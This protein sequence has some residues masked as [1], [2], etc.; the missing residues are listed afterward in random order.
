[1]QSEHEE[2]YEDG[3]DLCIDKIKQLEQQVKDGYQQG[4][5]EGAKKAM[6]ELVDYSQEVIRLK[7]ENREL[8]QQVLELKEKAKAWD[9]LEALAN[10]AFNEDEDRYWELNIYDSRVFL[11]SCL[12]GGTTI[13]FEA[14]LHDSLSEGVS[15]ALESI[16]GEGE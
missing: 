16:K 6:N 11:S 14:D 7:D 9:D 12:P 2:G 13:H 3:K 15:N 5:A 4:L 1:M 10:K 8:E